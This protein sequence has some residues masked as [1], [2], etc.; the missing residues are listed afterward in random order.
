[1][2]PPPAVTVGPKA[3]SSSPKLKVISTGTPA[4]MAWPT[5][6]FT[7]DR[8]PLYEARRVIGR[9]EYQV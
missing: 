4:T 9:S 3:L 1:M 5:G 7:L 2:L 6:V 8:V